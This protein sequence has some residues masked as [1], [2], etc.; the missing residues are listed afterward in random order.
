MDEVF[1][2]WPS[3][4]SANQQSGHLIF[5]R[6]QQLCLGWRTLCRLCHS[7][8]GLSYWGSSAASWD[9]CTKLVTFMWAL[10]ITAG[11]WVN[12]YIDSKYAFTAIHIHWAFYK[13]RELINSGRKSTK[14][15]QEIL[16]LLDAVWCPKWVAVIHCRGHQKGDVTIVCG[17]QKAD[18]ETKQVALTASPNCSDNWLV[19]MPLS[20]MG[21]TIRMG[22]I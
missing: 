8:F 13:E 22:F 19:P 15:G 11:V 6:W 10:Q 1:S 21:H 7:D 5:H 16:K 20:W 4:Q 2:G 12:L 17:N 9:F 14:Y 18:K 3:N